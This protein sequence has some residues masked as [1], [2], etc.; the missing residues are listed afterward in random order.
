MKQ[1]ILSSC[2]AV[3]L[4]GF[5]AAQAEI[6]ASTDWRDT[7]TTGDM[8]E[9]SFVFE[10]EDEVESMTF[11][12]GIPAAG[13]VSLEAIERIPADST[14]E[15]HL[16][17]PDGSSKPPGKYRVPL[18]DGV[19]LEVT[20]GQVWDSGELKL[21][22]VAELDDY[23]PNDEILTAMPIEQGIEIEAPLYPVGDVDYY[24][25]ELE[26][27]SVVSLEMN[28]APERIYYAFFDPDENRIRDNGPAE[29]PAG[30]NTVAV[31]YA[32][33]RYEFVEPYSF[34]LRQRVLPNPE[35]ELPEPE[36]L[37]VG[38]KSVLRRGE[39]D[40]VERKLKVD[41]PGLYTLSYSNMGDR[42]GITWINEAGE[43]LMS[44]GAFLNKG[45]YTIRLT[46]VT[47]PPNRIRVLTLN[48]SDIE[49]AFEPNDFKSEA[50]ILKS[51]MGQ[52]LWFE[53]ASPV[54]FFKFMP[55]RTGILSLFNLPMAQHC[56][57]Y[58]VSYYPDGT[59][60]S[61]AFM[62]ASGT[63]GGTRFGPVAVTKGE[64]LLIEM[65]CNQF[66]GDFG[67]T[68]DVEIL[69]ED[70][71]DEKTRTETPIYIVGF[72]LSEAASLGLATAAEETGVSFVRAGEGESLADEI[73][74]ALEASRNIRGPIN[75]PIRV[76][77]V[78]LVIA[79]GAG[80]AIYPSVFRKK[81]SQAD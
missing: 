7:G 5:S 38:A 34:R 33:R 79:A 8:A 61:K 68:M 30:K 14:T 39:V 44:H 57:A 54:E 20:G 73:S 2:L 41:K 76:I 31:W 10:V 24:S 70:F 63:R 56:G 25:F 3:S 19:R 64:P 36:P 49:D 43:E 21:S 26:Y 77:L 40:T 51:G 71:L 52:E 37:T 75:I 55:D 35:L 60:E 17:F 9:R 69:D 72:Q 32:N 27:P 66:N 67:Y 29:L 28:K 78:L 42:V 48:R 6:V 50:A 4:A 58:T 46:G 80:F 13:Y 53:K 15:I 18:P 59:P 74:D 11:D 12:P 23:E 81:K 22:W 65:V 62:P 1:L 47:E 16:L 45:D